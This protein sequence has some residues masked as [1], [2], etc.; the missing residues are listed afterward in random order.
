MLTI[1]IILILFII[2]IL[3]KI[4]TTSTT[5]LPITRQNILFKSLTDRLESNNNFKFVMLDPNINQIQFAQIPFE[6]T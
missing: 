6:P 5:Q 1:N 3:F 4:E 2:T